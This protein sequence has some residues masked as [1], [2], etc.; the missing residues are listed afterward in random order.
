M[1]AKSKAQQGFMGAELARKRAGK[2]TQTGMSEGQLSDFA[3]T[4]TKGLP[5]KVK[6]AAK[7]P[8]PK[9]AAPGGKG[10]AIGERPIQTKTA[11]KMARMMKGRY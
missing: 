1:P 4:K 3:G 6:P 7:A 8:A 2:A 11:T 10:L 9:P 5:E